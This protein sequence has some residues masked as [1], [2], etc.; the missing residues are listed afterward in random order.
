MQ[1]LKNDIMIF[2]TGSDDRGC[3]AERLQM[4]KVRAP[5]GSGAG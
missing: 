1:M 4:R 5:K 3:K 2:L